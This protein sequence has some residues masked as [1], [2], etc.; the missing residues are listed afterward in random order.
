MVQLTQGIATLFVSRAFNSAIFRLVSSTFFFASC[1]AFLAF[2]N[3]SARLRSY[4]L[5]GQM[6]GYSAGSFSMFS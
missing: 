2:A 6:K 4:F 1:S 5:R 3:F